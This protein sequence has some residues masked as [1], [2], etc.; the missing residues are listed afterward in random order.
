MSAANHHISVSARVLGSGSVLCSLHRRLP[1]THA[2]ERQKRVRPRTR[3]K[4]AARVVISTPRAAS[5]RL[6][7]AAG[8][9]RAS[10]TGGARAQLLAHRTCGEL[11]G[12]YYGV[13][14]QR[15]HPR[16]RA[17]YHRLALVG[18]PSGLC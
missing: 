11:V 18:S 5:L 2:Q 3:Q 17:W 6:A 1:Y 13:W 15:A 4:V 8:P 7:A 12:F 16:A 9:S 14:K 10:L